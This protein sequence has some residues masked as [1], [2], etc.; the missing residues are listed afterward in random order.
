MK[1]MIKVLVIFLLFL[2]SVPVQVI[3]ND[4][5]FS[6]EETVL[7][8]DFSEN[9]HID[10]SE[11]ESSN[12]EDV[13]KDNEESAESDNSETADQPAEEPVEPDNSETADQPAEEPVEPDN[14]ETIDQ[15]VEEPTETEENQ[16]NNSTVPINNAPVTDAYGR[17]LRYNR[18][19]FIRNP[20]ENS[21]YWS[22]WGVGNM[23]QVHLARSTD[24]RRIKL[25]PI[26]SYGEEVLTGQTFRIELD[27]PG[28]DP[29]R[30]SVAVTA[31]NRLVNDASGGANNS[32]FF[33]ES[34]G[35]NNQFYIGQIWRD[36]TGLPLGNRYVGVETGL[37]G[38]T[39][40][41]LSMS[42][43]H[44]RQVRTF[45]FYDGFTVPASVEGGKTVVG[46]TGAINQGATTSF[47]AEANP[48]YEFV[49][50]EITNTKYNP[51]SHLPKDAG[52]LST[53]NLRSTNYTM[54]D[55]NLEMRITPIFEQTTQRLTLS[56]LG[57][58]RA[59][60][61]QTDL[62]MGESTTI[63][64]TPNPFWEFDS[65][66]ISTGQG[67]EI[68]D[69][70][71]AVTTF[72]MGT[73]NTT[74]L[75]RFIEKPVLSGEVAHQTF[76]LGEEL[77]E[78]KLKKLVKNVTYN[79]Q[80]LA[81]DQYE[82][83][84]DG[85]IDTGLVG[86]Y[87][88]TATVTYLQSEIKIATI[89]EV[90]YGHTLLSRNGIVGDN[91][92]FYNNSTVALSLHTHNENP[93]LV[94]T[95]GYG[96][97]YSTIRSRPTLTVY[98]E[99]EK[100]EIT[101]LGYVT[102]NQNREALVSSWNGILSKSTP[103]YG[104]VIKMNVQM[105]ANT[106]EYMGR[107]S[108]ISRNEELVLET[109]GHKDAYYMITK[110]GFQLMRMNQLEKADEKLT[111][112]IGTTKEELAEQASKMFEFSGDFS[113]EERKQITFEV[114]SHDSTETSGEKK[115]IVKVTQTI[116]NVGTFSI[117]YEVDFTVEQGTVGEASHQTF[118]LGEGLT[119]DKIKKL[120]KNV[121]YNGQPLA[122][123]QY[124]VKIDGVLDTGLIG[125]YEVIATVKHA[126]SEVKIATTAEVKYGH[127]LLSK[128]GQQGDNTLFYSNS[129]VALSLHTHN[130]NPIL[131]AT[132]GYGNFY[133][134]IIRSRPTLTI[135]RETEKNEITN[136]VYGS[137]NQ[138]REALV[139][140]WN[141]KLSKSTPKYGDVV[142]MNVQMSAS[143]TEYMG[144]NSW[145]SRNEKLVRE[146]EGFHDAYYMLSK[147]G[148]QLLQMNQLTIADD[149]VLPRNISK[150]QL[151][152]QA[153]SFFKDFIDKD[154]F[155]YSVET[156][157]S[158]S[159][160]QELIVKVTQ[161]IENTGK[162]TVDYSV[163]V[164][165]ESGV[166]EFASLNNLDFNFG[167]IQPVMQ[168]QAIAAVGSHAPEITIS[169]YSDCT[170]W[171]LFVSQSSPLTSGNGKELTGAVISLE[172]ISTDSESNEFSIESKRIDLN[173]EPTQVAHMNKKNSDGLE[174]ALTTIQIGDIEYG[175]LT[176]VKLIIPKNTIVPS[177]EYRTSIEWNLVGDPTLI[178]E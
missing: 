176:G 146:T 127:T 30:M 29:N 8:D 165:V 31:D 177:G 169:D 150:E 32:Q 87:E 21:G 67:S 122:D 102:L 84:I 91:T 49:S 143:S 132:R 43:D 80:P 65:W 153:A 149:I 76:Y 27:R 77:T 138:T 9:E 63:T 129:T 68:A 70:Q 38:N 161:T 86:S 71:S 170:E 10:S 173:S 1:K 118:Y 110:D 120:V 119:E 160:Q 53:P 36:F 69:P 4:L 148:F 152:E 100:N 123:N 59:S 6:E 56:G 137:T 81:E 159:G 47:T 44:S 174:A 144:R 42:A 167:Q 78:D 18:W 25:V 64:A 11:E 94:A 99:T 39:V 19:Y 133:S 7:K 66:S 61:E 130:E 157:I 79:G 113:E 82:V 72:T 136:L 145:I 163:P 96:D 75:A 105:S 103:K 73:S 89:A 24:S 58:G 48:G 55:P 114:Q 95:R 128:N 121:T 92:Q 126:Q 14:S 106:N 98:R 155:E 34:A 26:G 166:L 141:G 35:G 20:R 74:V 134:S 60:A 108:W 5:N 97:F 37:D 104:D 107:N 2:G 116:P 147:S 90:K 45:S 101:N 125:N 52:S 13:Q 50:W 171:S 168:E 85:L 175:K 178:G 23:N 16:E 151:D 162:F 140:N 15:P 22:L 51:P 46:N 112:P 172:D 17:A 12:I 156:S 83:T 33:L 117:E 109:E 54:G 93:I 115:G 154:Q 3:G 142:K 62:K 164:F 41:R 88:I 124:E 158:H 28:A 111:V 57:G 40:A 135:Y 131:V 139:S